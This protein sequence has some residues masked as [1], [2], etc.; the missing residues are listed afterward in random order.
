MANK[1]YTCFKCKEKVVDENAITEEV[2][3]KTSGKIKRYRY[4]EECYKI[5]ENNRIEK[6]KF[7]KVYDY[8]R[9]EILLA[10]EGKSFNYLINRLQALR[11]GEYDSK[12]KREIKA[13]TY[14][15]M[16]YTFISCKKN[17]QDSI[18]I[19]DF[20]DENHMINYMMTIILNNIN[21]VCDRMERKK[22]SEDSLDNISIDINKSNKEYIKKEKSKVANILQD[23]M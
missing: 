1:Y 19:N 9:Y 8:V 6:Q 21:D 18:R 12:I 5:Y 22:K 7:N 10:R 4:H 23:L 16:Y 14:E 20:K 11:Y 2:V 17:I 15:Q 13:Y 3:S